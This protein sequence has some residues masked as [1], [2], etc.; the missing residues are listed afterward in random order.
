MKLA[1][2]ARD[3]EPAPQSGEIRGD[4]AV[5]FDDGSTVLDR[6]VSGDRTHATGTSFPLHEVRLL[7]P[8]QP[9][10]VFGVGLSYKTHA[11]QETAPPA[12]PVV[13]LKPPASV[14]APGAVVRCPAPVRELDYEGELVVV[15]GPD[16]EVAGYAIANDLTAR[17][18]QRDERQWARAKGFDGSCPFGP[19]VT[20]ADEV[21]DPLD[22]ALRTWVNGEPRQAA[23][24][25]DLMFSIR[26]LI[27]YIAETCTLQPGDLILT[28]TPGG[29]GM[30]FTPPRF[31][32]PG[33]VV[34]IEIEKL[35]AIQH[36]I[37]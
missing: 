17:D 13:F 12:R 34:R 6:L 30:S 9:R 15:M 5:A 3:S 1:Q 16:R 29:M 18:L 11:L 8:V 23:R 2:F 22:L 20:T 36:R 32:N 10:V 14:V 33:D 24:T 26:E 35:G 28:G 25:S 27:D 21:D 7:A 19:W 37:S 4:R 31:L